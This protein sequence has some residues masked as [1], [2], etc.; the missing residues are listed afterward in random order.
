[1]IGVALN[2]IQATVGEAVREV[3]G[4]AETVLGAL[5]QAGFAESDLPTR[6][7]SVRDWVDH[8]QQRVTSRVAT[9]SFAIVVRDLADVSGVVQ[10]LTDAAGDA[11]QIQGISFVHSDP[12]AL[13]AIARRNAIE[14]ANARAEQLAAAAGLRLGHVR[15]IQEGAAGPFSHAVA[16]AVASGPETMPVNPGNQAVSVRVTVE[17]ALDTSS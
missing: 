13:Q 17:F 12:A 6:N 1:M 16:R 2:S 14:D 8:Q 5:T 11:L 10:M 15:S 7:L 3:S 4:L 9:Y